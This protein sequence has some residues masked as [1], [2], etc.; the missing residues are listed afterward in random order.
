MQFLNR[1]VAIIKLKQPF[2]AGFL[3]IIFL[4][5]IS[6]CKSVKGSH[7]V[8]E[9]CD[10]KGA[11][12]FA[13]KM[14]KIDPNTLVKEQFDDQTVYHSKKLKF[15][16]TSW[17]H[18]PSEGKGEFVIVEKDKILT[19]YWDT[20]AMRK[21]ESGEA[22]PFELKGNSFS[23]GYDEG[24][25][26]IVLASNGHMVCYSIKE[27]YIEKICV[28]L[29]KITIGMEPNEI[30]INSKRHADANEIEPYLEV[31]SKLKEVYQP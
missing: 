6:G 9:Y 11:Y 12:M 27:N 8:S 24:I 18:M 3:M 28:N 29:K 21:V 30:P 23:Y 22:N 10:V 14:S 31:I 2:V 26:K 19:M 1:S 4:I 25:P 13:V 5:G 20:E 15:N 16:S 7:D 17:F